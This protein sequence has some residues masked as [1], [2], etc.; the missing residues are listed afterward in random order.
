MTALIA[1]ESY[2]TVRV[3][4]GQLELSNARPEEF[5]ALRDFWI[6]QGKVIVK[7]RR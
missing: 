7:V 2:P 5:G 1:I 6:L 3:F 4:W